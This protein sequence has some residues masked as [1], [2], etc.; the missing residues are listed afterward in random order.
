MMSYISKTINKAYSV[1]K[2]AIAGKI[3]E[4]DSEAKQLLRSLYNKK[5]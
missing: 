2:N 4:S 5:D 1:S 3:P